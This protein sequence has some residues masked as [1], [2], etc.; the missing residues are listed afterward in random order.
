MEMSNMRRSR[1]GSRTDSV[2]HRSS[3]SVV[4][5]FWHRITKPIT[6]SHAWLNFCFYLSII[7][8]QIRRHLNYYRIHFLYI[9]LVALLGGIAVYLS[10]LYASSGTIS[11]VDAIF[12]STSAVTQT[13]LSSVDVA[14]LH[15]GTQAVLIIVMMFGGSMIMTVAP[16][17][18]R[19][20]YFR[21][22]LRRHHI[23]SYRKDLAEYNALN[24]LLRIVPILWG[25]CLIS[26]YLML[27][28]YC[29]ANDGAIQVME[30]NNQTTAW[31]ALFQ[32]VSAFH[33]CGLSTISTNIVPFRFQYFPLLLISLMTVTGNVAFPFIM[34]IIVVA[35]YW[36]SKNPTTRAT[37]KFLLD[38]PRRCFTHLFP[39]AQNRWLLL[40][41]VVLTVVQ[42]SA[43]MGYEWTESLFAE[44]NA[45]EKIVNSFFQAAVTRSAGFNSIDLGQL[46]PGLLV[47]FL[48]M[49]YISVSPIAVAVRNSGLDG[50]VSSSRKTV[51]DRNV[52]GDVEEREAG[53]S[54][55]NTITSQAKRVMT[56]DSIFLFLAYLIIVSIETDHLEEDVSFTLFKILFDIISGYGTVG[57]SLGYP[58]VPFAFCGVWHP[59]SKLVL[60]LV[61]ILG[62]QRN[63]PD[64]IDKAVQVPKRLFSAVSSR[65]NSEDEDMENST[66]ETSGDRSRQH[67]TP[68]AD[69]GAGVDGGQIVPIPH[70]AHAHSQ[71]GMLAITIDN[72]PDVLRAVLW[73]S[74]KSR[75]ARAMQTR[76]L[77]APAREQ[78]LESLRVDND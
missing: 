52:M 28:I 66:A 61:M 24:A 3:P 43:L 55:S 73:K 37:Y 59:V 10:E 7:W 6:E 70:L 60:L 58:G 11:F 17:I 77:Q 76:K 42:W 21:K 35:R 33:N 57:L 51:L 62:R 69:S 22:Q 63:L 9:F 27:Y 20:F 56:Q 8:A 45:G 36:L 39:R 71:D 30:A 40:V 26:F 44:F 12:M 2:K 65:H 48:A 5:V 13:G 49:M 46:Q 34:R 50:T 68:D 18:M 19:K 38:H 14:E 41:F 53:R 74:C 54:S 4:S 16:V 29:I 23:E 47:L 15:Q 67:A 1:R 32:T 75:T 64:S 78:R 25:T 72:N 31:F